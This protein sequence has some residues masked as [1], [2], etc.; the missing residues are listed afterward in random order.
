M[1]Q[2]KK[3]LGYIEYRLQFCNCQVSGEQRNDTYVPGNPNYNDCETKDENEQDT[4]G[5]FFIPE[6]D[7][8]KSFG[9][10]TRIIA[11]QPMMTLLCDVARF[12][13]QVAIH[14]YSWRYLKDT[15][16]NVVSRVIELQFDGLHLVNSNGTVAT[17]TFKEDSRYSSK[18]FLALKDVQHLE[19]KM[20]MQ[21]KQSKRGRKPALEKNQHPQNFD[22]TVKV[23]AIS[24]IIAIDPTDPFAL[25]EVYDPDSPQTT[26]III[27]KGIGA[28][29]CQ[30]A[31]LPGQILNFMNVTRSR[32]HIPKSFQ[33]S[34]VPH[35]LRS[36]APSHVFVVTDSKS[37]Q[38]NRTSSQKLH[39]LPSTVHP[40]HCI[41][42]RVKHIQFSEFKEAE[43]SESDNTMSGKVIHHVMIEKFTGQGE[44]ILNK[45]YL[46]YLP[47][48]PDLHHGMKV[49]SYICAMN[50]HLIPTN[51]SGKHYNHFCFGAC[52]RST[53]II[54]ALVSDGCL[55]EEYDQK[56][57]G[58]HVSKSLD[59]V[60]RKNQSIFSTSSSYRQ[61]YLFKNIRSSYADCEWIVNTQLESFRSLKCI[62]S[63]YS[64]LDLCLTTFRVNTNNCSCSEE[65]IQRD[66]YKEWFDHACED[67]EDCSQVIGEGLTCC[68][69]TEKQLFPATTGLFQVRSF[70]IDTMNDY[71]EK[72]FKGFYPNLSSIHTGW[73]KTI[74]L[75]SKNL[76][77]YYASPQTEKDFFVGGIVTQCSHKGKLV[78][79]IQDSCCK[80]PLFPII[81]CNPQS[82]TIKCARLGQFF[83]TKI[84]SV[85]VTCFY[86]GKNT[87]FRNEM[88]TFETLKLPPLCS[89]NDGII[90]GSC[91]LTNVNGY[92]FM[93]G[94]QIHYLLQSHTFLTESKGT[95][96]FTYQKKC[97]NIP[98]TKFIEIVD[99]KKEFKDNL[100]S[101]INARLVCLNWKLCKPENDHYVGCTMNLSFLPT[102]P[103]MEV[104]LLSRHQS[105]RLKLKIP[106]QQDNID[107]INKVLKDFSSSVKLMLNCIHL[108]SAWREISEHYLRCPLVTCGDEGCLSSNIVATSFE[109]KNV[110]QVQEDAFCF[111]DA[112][113]LSI[114]KENT[115]KGGIKN[116]ISSF[117]KRR[118]LPGN[119]RISTK[120][121]INENGSV[122][123]LLAPIEIFHG[124][125]T[126]TIAS[127]NYR[128]LQDK[129]LQ[130]QHLNLVYRIANI[131]LLALRFC[132]IRIQCTKCFK[133]LTEVNTALSKNYDSTGNVLSSSH[134]IKIERH[135]WNEPLQKKRRDNN[136][137]GQNNKYINSKL[138]CPSGCMIH[139][140]V[141][142]WELSAFVD[143]NTGLAKLYAERD[144][145]KAFL[146]SNLNVELIE[147]A[148]WQSE[149]GIVYQKGVVL[150]SKVKKSIRSLQK[151]LFCDGH[152]SVSS[153]QGDYS[154]DIPKKQRAQLELDYFAKRVRGQLDI[155]CRAKISTKDKIGLR[156]S[157]L[158][159]IAALGQDGRVYSSS[160]KTNTVPLLELKLEDCSR[161]VED[162]S[163][164]G[165]SILQ[166][167]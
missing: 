145:A 112:I 115:I 20:E 55:I 53:V 56:F 148:A 61:F 104:D 97:H 150:N 74:I 85:V 132:S 142:K 122:G 125:P 160:S 87:E 163:Q 63:I 11:S 43:K 143:D 113:H 149:Q 138:K 128:L 92:V 7:K 156:Q 106:L 131:Q 141:P 58:R 3:L 25:I 69:M 78:C 95:T 101:V 93:I 57:Q 37:V 22:I 12:H 9:C 89:G 5:F 26:A 48:S 32:W 52:L 46:F 164:S 23:D 83:M 1:S 76:S 154:R 105:T 73:T 68:L 33:K 65:A 151:R 59:V 39:E 91:Q 38:W 13:K 66:P 34:N 15:N 108:A 120:R 60:S 152:V 29:C 40:L 153:R 137:Y 49:G 86:I 36:R 19:Q 24:T 158:C 109:T 14:K 123:K 17:N 118:Y 79:E 90:A 10:S 98:L 135:F 41:D 71:L 75:G 42:G 88:D 121:K 139:H 165:W 111:V 18:N 124:L 96:S 162:A 144:V 81:G 157:D 72:T 16:H 127:M 28:L 77:Q 94:I 133:Y 30:P 166:S 155:I 140:A 50:I 161:C 136:L 146:G 126:M 129:I 99:Q 67:D 35:R 44:K 110:L 6:T 64:V 100:N 147:E 134:A 130:Q 47:Q 70:A 82:L 117:N 159:T 102:K 84:H 4:V 107:S 114:R 31:I 119:L 8:E 103:K 2:L 45:L 27:L 21:R 167:L 116:A 51:Y 80:I 62:N 54:T